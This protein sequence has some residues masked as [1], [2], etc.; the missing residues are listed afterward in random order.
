[1]T[2]AKVFTA[3]YLLTS[4]HAGVNLIIPPTT[5]V[6]I[7]HATVTTIWTNLKYCSKY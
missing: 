4:H 1:M 5:L 2:C 7:Q 6:S 3:D